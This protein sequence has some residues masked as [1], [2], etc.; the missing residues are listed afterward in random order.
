MENKSFFDKVSN[1]F[2]S[3]KDSVNNFKEKV[4]NGGKEPLELYDSEAAKIAVKDVSLLRVY[5]L[6]KD[7]HIEQ[8][9]KD[10]FN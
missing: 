4:Y 6:A 10:F 3:L 5:L 8:T 9:K 1:W 2:T 7:E